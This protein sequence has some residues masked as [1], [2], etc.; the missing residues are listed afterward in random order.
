MDS[1]DASSNARH[2]YLAVAPGMDHAASV[3]A[4]DQFTRLDRA[5]SFRLLAGVPVGG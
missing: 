1:F 4:Q 3:A 2:S 5:E